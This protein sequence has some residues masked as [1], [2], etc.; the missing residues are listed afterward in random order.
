MPGVRRADDATG[1]TNLELF[2]DL[3]FVFAITQVSHGLL[4]HLT[5]DGAGQTLV[6]L[7]AIWWTWNFTTW[8]TNELDPDSSAVRGLLI[9]LMLASLTMA[10]AIPEAFGERSLLFAGAYV[11]IQLSRSAFLSFLGG[12]PGSL[13][14]ERAGNLL[15]WFAISSPLWIAGGVADGPLRTVLWIAAIAWDYAGPLVTFH[16]PGRP[17]APD[18]WR[19]EP[20]HM[21]E[22]FQLFVIIALGESIV[23]TGSTTSDLDLDLAR[24]AAFALAFLGA[25]ALWWLYF[26]GVADNVGRMLARATG[27]RTLVARDLF[28]YLHVILIA[29]IVVSA[30]GNEIVIAHPNETL[31]NHD[32]LAV[33][34]GPILYLLAQDLM[35]FR[36]SRDLSRTRT[37]G[38][39]ACVAVGFAAPHVSAL[40]TA[41]LLVVVLA[42]VILWTARMRG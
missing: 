1:V 10:I 21:A 6:I 41:A 39:L 40:I 5:W 16:L 11:I 2:Y 30:V 7:L 26:G 4:A 31:D 9:F 15:R 42:A 25:A 20:E 29:G 36:A 27:D 35:R 12:E 33:V 32:V 23:V 34:A 24:A 38:I 8:A 13:E 22:R 3:V 18:A 14:R 28:T 19:V 37:A 17:M